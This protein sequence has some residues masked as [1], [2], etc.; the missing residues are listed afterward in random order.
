DAPALAAV[1]GVSFHVMDLPAYALG[2]ALP[3]EVLIS[4][5]AAG[6]GWSVGDRLVPGRVD[7]QTVL[8]HE[9]GHVF[10]LADD[11]GSALMATFLPP[12]VRRGPEG[13]PTSAT[14]A[15]LAA[16]NSPA[17]RGEAVTAS[18]AG[19]VSG[20]A[21]ERSGTSLSVAARAEA[22]DATFV[23]TVRS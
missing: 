16:P 12:G 2:L 21:A 15:P 1:D 22:S 6:L 19:V 8:A 5:D 14:V 4:P 17:A 18:P 3:G 10:G 9:L 20:P 11:S 7:L 23:V 13:P